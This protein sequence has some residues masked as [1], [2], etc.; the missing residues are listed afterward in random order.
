MTKKE[1]EDYF[2]AISWFEHEYSN[3][4]AEG[5]HEYNIKD[6]VVGMFSVWPNTTILLVS[7]GFFM[8]IALRN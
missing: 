8:A 4:K 7:Q 6:L 1:V 5:T 2:E 3:S